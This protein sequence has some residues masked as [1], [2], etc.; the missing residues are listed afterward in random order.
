MQRKRKAPGI[1]RRALAALLTL[2]LA[3]GQ[4]LGLLGPAVTPALADDGTIAGTCTLSGGRY[5]ADEGYTA[6]CAMPD[7]QVLTAHCYERYLGVDKHEYY[8]GPCDGTYEFKA[9]RQPDGSYRVV[10]YSQDAACSYDGRPANGMVGHKFQHAVVL[11]W[12][13]HVDVSFTKCS[14]DARVTAGNSE[15]AYAGAEYDIYRASDDSLVAHITTDASGH[16]G[17]Q[18]SPNE[19]YYAV[20]TKAPQGFQVNTSRIEFSTGNSEGSEQLAD[21]PGYVL[22][23]IQ[24]EDS[25]TLGDAQPGATLEGAEYT[26]VSKSTP[27]W[28]ATVTTNDRGYALATKVPFGDIEVRETKAP[29]GY[30]LDPT[31]HPY[32]VHAGQ[33]TNAGTY[34][35]EPE[36]DCAE[37]VKAFDLEIAKTL[38]SPGEWDQ[39]DGQSKPAPGVRF[40]VI[41]NTTHEVVGTLT[42]NASGLASTKDASTCDDASVS[43]ERTDDA[44]R[45][46]FGKGRRNAGIDGAIPYD[47]AGYTIH[48]VESTVP[49]GYASPESRD[50]EM[51]A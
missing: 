34:D 42:T 11:D 12:R 51:A 10:V 27:G 37:T 9:D 22:L 49:D 6:N 23:H 26:I 5:D 43:E 31:V 39:G 29:K 3:A 19:H 14:A 40:Q 47:E 46:W 38:G 32:T 1:A 2:A 24:K 16:A 30:R 35:L 44:T 45:P 21:D 8:L 33:I 4:W 48:E 36:D 13:P 15:Y 7:G 25:A 28:S 18:L 20:E 41:S 17:Y 50:Y